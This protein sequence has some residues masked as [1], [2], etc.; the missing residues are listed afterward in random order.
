M[1]K[2]ISKLTRRRMLSDLEDGMTY[3]ELKDKYGI[4]DDRTL[5][6]HLA[7]AEQEREAQTVKM[8]VLKDALKNHLNEV[9]SLIELWKD[10]NI[11]DDPRV[12]H[13]PLFDCLKQHLHFP[14]LW[15]DYDTW[16]VK[17]DQ[18][19][20]L[21]ESLRKQLGDKV[22]ESQE[23]KDSVNEL[24]SLKDRIH[25]ALERA[26]LK[27]DYI[28]YSCDLCPGQPIKAKRGSKPQ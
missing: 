22:S 17:N 21:Y 8:E 9:H 15:R 26:L 6:K 24:K 19:K 10:S 11:V 23:V 4:G 3:T 5:K 20:S 12:I 25:E 18:H 2:A 28:L 27:R 13:S 7:L 16:R 14:T 1:R